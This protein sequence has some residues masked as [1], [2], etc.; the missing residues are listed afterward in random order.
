MTNLQ[1]PLEYRAGAKEDILNHYKNVTMT[2]EN[3]AKK[4]KV[5]TRTIQ[6]L[7][8]KFRLTRTL[9]KANHVTVRLKTYPLAHSSPAC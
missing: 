8:K 4:Y 6:R 9:T 3:L 1:I 7:I 5:T 2:V